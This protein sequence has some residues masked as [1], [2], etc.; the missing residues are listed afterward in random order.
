MKDT[1]TKITKAIVQKTIASKNY[2]AQDFFVGL[3]DNPT[4]RLFSEH[5]VDK[6]DGLYVYYKA[7]STE[8]AQKAFDELFTLDMNGI[9]AVEGEYVYCYHINGITVEC[10]KGN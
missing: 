8:E 4:K 2:V 9:T 5:K 7:N 10:P 6:N 1:H 3:T